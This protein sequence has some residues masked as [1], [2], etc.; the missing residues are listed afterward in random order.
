MAIRTSLFIH[1]LRD[2]AKRCTK[3]IEDIIPT[4]AL[5]EGMKKAGSV[6][7]RSFRRK[8]ESSIFEALIPPMAGLDPGFHRGDD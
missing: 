8:P 3:N 6:F 1:P 4:L 5:P 7:F 2:I